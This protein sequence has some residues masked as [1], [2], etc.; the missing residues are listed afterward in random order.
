MSHSF[1]PTT[2]AILL[3]TCPDR[4]G[5]V[6]AISHFLYQHD[7]N[8]IHADQHQDTETGLF[9][10]RIEWNPDGGDLADRNHFSEA[11]LPLAEKLSMKWKLAYL[12]E[13][14]R[15]A[16]FVSQYDHCLADLLYRNRAGDLNCEISLVIGNHR[17]GSELARFYGIPFQEIALTARNPHQ[18]EQAERLQRELL[19]KHRIDVIILAR[20]MQILSP[21]FVD[22]YPNQIINIHHSFLPAFQGAKPYHQAYAR[23]VK[24]IGATSHYVTAQLDEGPIIHQDVLRITHRDQVQDIVQKGRDLETLVLSRAV[25]WHLEHRIVASGNK[26]VVLV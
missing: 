20:Y 10:M 24:L 25:K 22:A 12:D 5:L 21:A 1:S 16:I 7:A 2:K 26:T 3:L 11:F 6:A 14:P 9:L 23:G 15:V 18:K 19:Q 8:I 13:K 17:N 4:K